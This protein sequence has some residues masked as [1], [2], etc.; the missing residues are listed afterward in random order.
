MGFSNSLLTHIAI[1]QKR[2]INLSEYIFHIP[3]L[4]YML[5]DFLYPV[6]GVNSYQSLQPN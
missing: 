4:E 6:N 1:F 2:Y 5:F 3:Y